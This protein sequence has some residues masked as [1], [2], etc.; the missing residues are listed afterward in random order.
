MCTGYSAKKY[1]TAICQN[2]TGE[3]KCPG[4]HWIVPGGTIQFLYANYG[5][6]HVAEVQ[7]WFEREMHLCQF[8][9]NSQ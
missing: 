1:Y 6:R 3:V 4:G 8:Q 9:N 7:N 2:K 5:R